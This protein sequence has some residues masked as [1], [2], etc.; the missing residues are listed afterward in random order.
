MHDRPGLPAARALN[1]RASLDEK[2]EG[3]VL[4]ESAFQE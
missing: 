2:K 3:S 1:R 4:R